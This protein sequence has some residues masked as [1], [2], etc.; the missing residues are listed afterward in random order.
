M[1]TKSEDLTLK[2]IHKLHHYWGHSNVDKFK[3]LIDNSGR[4]TD[5]VKKILTEVGRSCESCKVI[6]NR[7][8][9]PIV[10][11]PKAFKL[12]YIISIDLK[13]YR[14]DDQ[15]YILYGVDVFSRFTVGAFIPDKKAETEY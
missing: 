13:E 11:I 4:L 6:S 5:A 1:I 12:N 15:R 3:V 14:H 7:K 9:T 2:E 8:P 10:S